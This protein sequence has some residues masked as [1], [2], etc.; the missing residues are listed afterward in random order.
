MERVVLACVLI[1]LLVVVISNM[2]IEMVAD[3]DLLRH[4]PFITL[5]DPPSAR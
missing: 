5:D 3:D 4:S 2:H 1:A